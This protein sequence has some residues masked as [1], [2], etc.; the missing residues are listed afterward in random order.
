M[1]KCPV[2]GS[3]RM[4]E[5]G[6][7]VAYDGGEIQYLIHSKSRL[8]IHSEMCADCGYIMTFCPAYAN[9]AQSILSIDKY[10]IDAMNDYRKIIKNIPEPPQPNQK[11]LDQLK[12]QLNR[13]NEIVNDEN[14]T[15]KAVNEA[16][17]QILILESQIKEEERV[18]YLQQKDIK[19]KEQIQNY[20][21]GMGFQEDLIKFNHNYL[22]EYGFVTYFKEIKETYENSFKQM[23][24]EYKQILIDAIH[25]SPLVKLEYK[26]KF[27][28]DKLRDPISR[29][30][31]KF[32]RRW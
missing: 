13:S 18:F 7:L 4:M 8:S 29:E 2:C 24:I 3:E 11:K 22:N 21:T 1:K 6:K 19:I 12:N 14:Q 30:L 16:K 5:G 32:T 26:I 27:P 31:Y 28:F 9:V 20:F 25:S 17:Q 10:I 15:V 23:L